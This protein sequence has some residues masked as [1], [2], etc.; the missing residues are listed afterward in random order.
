VDEMDVDFSC[1]WSLFLGNIVAII[2]FPFD[3]RKKGT[4]KSFLLS[5][6]KL[7]RADSLLKITELRGEAANTNSI[8]VC[9]RANKMGNFAEKVEKEECNLTEWLERLTANSKV[10]TAPGSIPASSDTVKP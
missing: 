10:A 1:A 3:M 2:L 9:L 6:D 4:K 5:S 7:C 8:L